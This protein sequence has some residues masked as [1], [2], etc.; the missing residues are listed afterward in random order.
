MASP[1]EPPTEAEWRVLRIVWEHGPCAARDVVRRAGADQGWSTSTVKTLL[2]RLVEKGHLDAERVGNSFRYRTHRSPLPFLRGAADSL[3]ENAVEGTVVPL[4]AYMVRRSRLSEGELQ[5]L[6]DL[7]GDRRGPDEGTG[8]D[9]EE[10][11]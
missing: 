5:E 8:R 9:A 4:L 11:R 10:P 3:L 2:R 1:P 7:L 6:R